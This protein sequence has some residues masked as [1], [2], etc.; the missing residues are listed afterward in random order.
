MFII[1][2][3]GAAESVQKCAKGT[4]TYN[5]ELYVPPTDTDMYFKV[6]H[7]SLFQKFQPKMLS[8]LSNGNGFCN[9]KFECPYRKDECSQECF[10]ETGSLWL[11]LYQFLSCYSFLFENLSVFSV[12]SFRPKKK[13]NYF[14]S[15][16]QLSN[17]FRR[18]L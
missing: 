9:W 5:R 12:D 2:H 17:E 3:S 10:S 1:K 7:G 16:Q 8:S 6:Y 18:I 4:T 11:M 14:F 15:F 13:N